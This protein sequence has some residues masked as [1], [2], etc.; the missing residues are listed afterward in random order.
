MRL[1]AFNH[2]EALLLSKPAAAARLNTG[3]Y[4]ARAT[5]ICALAAATR[6]SAAATSGRRSSNVDGKPGSIG[7]GAVSVGKGFESRWKPEGFSP[8]S[9]AIACSVLGA[10]RGK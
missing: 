7:G 1:G 8:I 6:R 9:T 3:K 10:R 4:A 2:V 5:P